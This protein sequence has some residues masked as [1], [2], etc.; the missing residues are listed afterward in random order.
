MALSRSARLISGLNGRPGRAGAGAGA[1]GRPCAPARR[2]QWTRD[3]WPAP[4]PIVCPSTTKQTELDWVYLSVIQAMVRSRRAAAGQLAAR[5]DDVGEVGRRDGA[6]VAALLEGDAEDLAGLERPAARRRGRS[7]T[8]AYLPCFFCAQDL[9]RRRL[10]AGGDDA[11]GD[12]A[13]QH[14]GGGHVDGVRERDEVAEGAQPVGAA[15]A[16][17]GGG[18]RRELEVV[19]EVGLGAASSESGTATAAPGGADVLERRRG[20]QAGGLLELA[21]KLPGVQR[22]RAG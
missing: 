16:G 14:A 6:V 15:G 1:R 21:D 4:T 2:T 7:R 18:Q 20:G 5:G 3:C 17:V 8:T 22:R 9:E 12:L 19:H 10:V 11:V 13:R